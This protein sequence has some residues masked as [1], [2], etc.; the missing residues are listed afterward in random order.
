MT[1][2]TIN[3]FYASDKKYLPYLSVAI[4]SLSENSSPDYEYS[5]TV[6][7]N[8]ISEDDLKLLRHIVRSNIKINSKNVSEKIHDIQ[9]TLHRK[10]RDYYSEAIYYR[11][12]IPSLFPDIKKAVY[13]DSD[14]VLCDDVARLYFTDL[15]DNL[16]GAVTD[17]TVIS[18]PIFSEYVTKYIGLP[19]TEY[20]FNSGVILMD[21]SAMREEKLEERFLYILKNYNFNTVAPDQDYLNLLCL[22]RVKYLDRRWN[23]HSIVPEEHAPEQCSIGIAHYNMFQKPWRY[24][25][26]ANEQIFWRAAAKTPYLYELLIEKKN[27][28]DKQK[29]TDEDCASRLNQTITQILQSKTPLSQIIPPNY[30][31]S[32]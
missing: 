30:F 32:V 18:S 28:S 24:D 11:L 10:L 27:Y 31:E 8:D 12:F 14:T 1:K 4:S 20:Y 5:I 2:E 23:K 22:G 9:A 6:L 7:T 25:G 17:E 15:G 29:K 3:I 26:V 16:I 21:L 13:L 19:K